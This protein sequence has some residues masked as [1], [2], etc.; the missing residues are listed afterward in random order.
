MKVIDIINEAASRGVTRF[1]YEL[2]P[3]LKGEN[4]DSVFAT[5]ERL[6]RFN[7]AYINITNHREEVQYVDLPGGGVERR[8]VRKRP[9]TVSI[10]AAIKMKYSTEVVPHLICGGFSKYDIEI[11]LIELNFLG[12]RNVLALRGDAAKGERAFVPHPEGYAN[13]A[14]LVRQIAEMNRGRHLDGD[15][16]DH[17]PTGFCAGV[18]GYP[19]KHIEAPNATTDL[20]YLKEKV[21]AGADYIVTQ[22]FFDNRKYFDFVDRCRQAGINVPIIP[23]LKPLSTRSQLTMLPQIFHVDIPQELV[24]AVEKCADN[25]QVRQAGIDWAVEQSQELKAAGVPVLHFYSMGKADN[26]EQIAE[27]VF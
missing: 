27:R 6:S 25:R 3:P 15:Q 1:A 17:S 8:V 12:I 24:A 18:A 16:D 9:G 7:P 11:S 10:A 22:M 4:I 19:E 14:G 23:G 2:L 21:D 20:M 13:A 5:V 26:I